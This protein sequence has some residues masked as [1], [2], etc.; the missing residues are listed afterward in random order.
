MKT[1]QVP[2]PLLAATTVIVA[3]VSIRGGCTF[4]PDCRSFR[5]TPRTTAVT[6]WLPRH[7]RTLSRR[8]RCTSIVAA[9][10]VQSAYITL[11]EMKVVG[12]ESAF[13]SASLEL[14]RKAIS[15]QGLTR[16][17]V[18]Q[19]ISSPDRFVFFSAY[20]KQQGPAGHMNSKHYAAWYAATMGK[21]VSYTT[22]KW[23][24]VYPPYA[25]DFETG[26]LTL[27]R[28]FPTNR[29]YSVDLVH[30]I[31]NVKPGYESHFEKETTSLVKLTLAEY[32]NSCLRYF[33]LRSVENPQRFML[34][35]V[36]KNKE[37]ADSA[38]MEPYYKQ[39]CASIRT[40]LDGRGAGT[41]FVS[42]F[43]NYDA[44]WW[45]KA[46]MPSSSDNLF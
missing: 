43:P 13:L 18:L 1:E 42:R 31:L 29:D 6:C 32:T 24:T 33:L 2:L 5:G 26:V 34:I 3:C 10:A 16:F 37:K 8:E 44:A 30:V 14:A 40:A 35:Q 4:L 7:T 38:K 46:R 9:T 36:F 20:R 25:S 15:E 23:D 27:E 28:D 21:I 11:A 17:E 45:T 19:S 41:K 39:W 12:Q 22:T